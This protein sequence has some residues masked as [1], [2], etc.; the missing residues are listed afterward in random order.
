[1]T[2]AAPG[3][4]IDVTLVA[5]GMYHDVD[6]AR[7]E[8]LDA[9]GRARGVPRPGPTRLRGHRRHRRRLDPR[10]LHLQRP[11]EPRGASNTI[12][13]WVEGGGRWVALHG[14]NSALD[15]GTPNGVDS[16]RVFP[17]WAD[18]LGSQFVAHPPI[19]P[20]L[21]ERVDRP[22]TGSSPGIE[23]F[24]T[25]D[26]LYLSE[27]ADRDRSSRCCTPPG[28]EPH[29][30][31]SSH[32]WTHGPD[33][34]LVMYLRELG[35]GAVLYNTL[36]HCRG[37]YDMVPVV[38]YYP[39]SSADPGNNLPTSSSC[40]DRYGGPA[41]RPNRSRSRRVRIV[42]LVAAAMSVLTAQGT[43][44]VASVGRRR[45]TSTAP[46]LA[47]VCCAPR[48]TRASSSATKAPPSPTS[49]GGPTCRLR[50]STATSAARP[51]CWSKR[52]S[53][54][55]T[56]SPRSRL[57]GEAGIRE[58]ARLLAAARHSPPTRILVAELHCAAI[59]QPEVAEL[60][61]DWQRENAERL[62]RQAGLTLS[63]IKHVLPVAARPVPRR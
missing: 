28:P 46:R 42:L 61:G 38:D 24:E 63:Q 41:V 2:D 22:T 51:H 26:E 36:G 60:L 55:S 11:P 3:S 7:R 52:S 20:Y 1:M 32:D 16:P 6:F 57:P 27:H 19:T 47:S 37:H 48:S 54:S 58:I 17:L 4:R 12:R 59:R 15:V 43:D 56:R 62:Q 40:D 14:T 10:Q 50:R 30:D 44:R 35:D 53:T 49:H 21:V 39:R 33:R 31:S 34:H 29:A 8:L 45:S 5:G 13:D 9:A 25:D 18:T 23:P